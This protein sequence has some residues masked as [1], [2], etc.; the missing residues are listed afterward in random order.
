MKQYEA[1]DIRNIVLT[2]HA[3]SGK[4]SLTE[5]L[6]FRAGATDRL[7]KIADG[8]TVCDY[9]PEEIRRKTTVSLTVAPME[10]KNRKF[11]LIDVPGL[12]DFEQGLREGMRA[13][14][15]ALI[16]ISGKSGVNVGTEKAFELASERQLARFFFVNKLDS[17]HADFYRVLTQLKTEFGPAVCPLVVPFVQDHRV[18]CYVDMLEYKAYRYENGK[19][20]D[21][22]IPDMGERLEGL[23]TAIYEAVAET[24]EEAFEQYFSGE[25]FTPEQLINGLSA[26]VRNGTI[27]P[28]FCGASQTTD[29]VDMLLKGLAWLAPTAEK[30]AELTA[31]G[32]EL[33]VDA[34]GKAAAMVFHTVSDPFVGKLSYIKVISGRI[35]PDTTL[36]NPRTGAQEKPG[37]LIFLRGKR[38]EDTDC[39]PAGDIGAIA[40]LQRTATGDT[41]CAPDAPVELETIVPAHA[42]LCMAVLPRSKGD[43]EKI[44]QGVARMMEEDPVLR[45]EN[46]QETHQLLLYGLGDQHL[47]VVASR[48]KSRFG[49]DVTLEKPRVAYRETIRKKVAVQGRHKKQTG[50]HGQFGDV[51]IEFEPCDC[52]GLEF[53]ERVVGGAVPKGFFPAV[54]KGLRDCIAHGSLAGYPVVGVRATLY[55]GSYHP[56][57]SSEMS[58]KMAATLAYKAGMPQANPVLLEPIG[59]LLVEVPDANMGDIIGEINKRRGRVL[60]MNPTR[61]GYQQIEAEAPVAEMSDFTTFLRQA[62]QGRGSYTFDFVRYEEAPPAVVQKVVAEARSGDA[63]ES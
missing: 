40:K 12:F 15:T 13:A 5:A 55:D 41:L 59:T 17:D 26:G 9:D 35:T 18:Q 33:P 46:N 62:A 14:E 6:L 50:G 32:D 10:W 53:G 25:A 44:A 54:E 60:G 20:I 51:W 19:A 36:L 48:L 34:S 47:D 29:G 28:V 43:E 39:I 16:N 61:R 24:S 1:K 49:V 45:L 56:V 31:S 23:R 27:Y 30:G 38:Q 21:V 52:D 8:T 58:F 22:P 57:D 37:K 4:T 42:T 3:N 2:G 7:G 63:A 11:N